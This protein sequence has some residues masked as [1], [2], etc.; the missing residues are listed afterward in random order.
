[1]F[2]LLEQDLKKILK[3]KG[4]NVDKVKRLPKDS[5]QKKVYFIHVKNYQLALNEFKR[6]HYMD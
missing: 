6:S 2:N 1:M 5:G 4:I 3:E